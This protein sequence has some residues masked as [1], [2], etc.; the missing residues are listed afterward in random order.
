MNI[1]VHSVYC[2]DEGNELV[3]WVEYRLGR[4]K[5]YSPRLRIDKELHKANKGKDV[6]DW[7]ITQGIKAAPKT[8]EDVKG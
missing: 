5:T 1:P 7:L 4:K 6:Q 3:F 2:R 8:S